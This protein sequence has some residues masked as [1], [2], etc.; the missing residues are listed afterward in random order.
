MVLKLNLASEILEVKLY[1]NIH[2]IDVSLLD[3]EQTSS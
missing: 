1:L 2:L 3:K